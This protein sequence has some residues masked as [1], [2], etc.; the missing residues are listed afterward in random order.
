MLCD[1]IRP[2][3]VSVYYAIKERILANYF[4]RR[5]DKDRW[6]TRNGFRQ[7]CGRFAERKVLPY[8]Y[9]KAEKH[10]SFLF[11]TPKSFMD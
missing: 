8:G 7:L 6:Q 11:E 10:S 2:S 1:Q 3:Q 9:L 5:N 4:G